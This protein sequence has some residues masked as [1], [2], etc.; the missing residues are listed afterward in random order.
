MPQLDPQ[1]QREF[2]VTVVGRLRAEGHTAYWAGGCVRDQ[3]LGLMPKD[4]DVATSAPPE[5]VRRI[6]THNRTLAIGAAFG[7][8]TVLGPWRAGQ[9]EVATFRE[10][11]GYTDGRH[12]DT[13]QFSTAELDAHRRD[14]TINGLF[15]DPVD[16]RIIDYVL[17]QRDL[18]EGL[19]RAIGNPRYRFHEDRLRMLRAVRL[20]AQFGFQLEVETLHAI[21]EMAELLTAVS[22]ER[23]GSEMRRMLEHPTRARAVELL[24]ETKLLAVVLPELE[25]LVADPPAGDGDWRE[26]LLVLRTLP[27]GDLP[28]ALAAVLHRINR[29]EAHSDRK[30]ANIA[31][32]VADRL[33][34]PRKDGA[35]AAW[36]LNHL[37][38][39]TQARQ[40]PWPRLQ[41]VL[42]FDGTEQLL[43]LH[44]AVQG[45]DDPNLQY[46]RAKL[47]LPPEQLNPAPLIGGDDLIAHGLKPGK[48]FQKLLDL[49][50]D[51][52]LEGK[53]ATKKEALAMVDAIMQERSSRR[54]S[55]TE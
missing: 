51:A 12:P 24:R 8:I 3:L 32:Q 15:Y 39:I 43:T 49:V 41:R 14:F 31:E 45:E 47:Q 36:I 21:R 54:T 38:V 46:C 37:T 35:R 27:E 11:L 1:Q 20:A 30:H 19:V 7:V 52:Q 6:F 10:D 25:A 22:A 55:G 44:A 2:A 17:G 33:R 26:T 4:Y 9:I 48:I 42:F 40:I 29:P 50:R 28:L 18:R 13:V 16:D 5:E 23:I 34:L 53:L